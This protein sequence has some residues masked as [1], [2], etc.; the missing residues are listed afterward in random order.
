MTYNPALLSSATLIMHG[1]KN[2]QKQPNPTPQ[3][4]PVQQH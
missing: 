2:Q 1:T 3:T 4:A